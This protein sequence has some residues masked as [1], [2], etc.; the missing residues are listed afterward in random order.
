[1]T[2]S[3]NLR[4]INFFV[5][6]SAAYLQLNSICHRSYSGNGFPDQGYVVVPDPVAHESVGN[7]QLN[8]ILFHSDKPDRL[9]PGGKMLR[10]QRLLEMSKCFMPE[11]IH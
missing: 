2:W 1:M 6:G 7:L 3:F 4:D 8:H 9:D 5:A 10:I 11:S